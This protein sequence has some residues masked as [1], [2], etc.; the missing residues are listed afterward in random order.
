MRT[1]FIGFLLFAAALLDAT[2][3]LQ[4]R[5][6]KAKVG[7]YIVTEGGQMVTLLAI[8]S[9]HSGTLI[10][11]E[12]SA[13]LSRLQ[14]M[15]TS[16]PEWI[17]AKAPGHT[18]W[19]M[20]EIDLAHGQVLECFSFSRSAWIQT[21]QN[22]SLIATLLQLPLKKVS[23]EARKKIGPAPL[24]DEPDRRK[25]W[26]PP[27]MHEGK[28][29]EGARFDAFEAIWPKDGTELAGQEVL[30]YFDQGKHF[31]LPFWVEINTSHATV[32]LRTIDSGINIPVIHKSMPRRAPEFIG[33]ALK[34]E[35]GLR[36]SIK[37]PKYYRQ[38]E[39]FAIDIT[40]RDK[41]ICPITHFAS[42]ETGEYLTLDID[43]DELQ[44]SLEPKHHYTW[45][46]VPIGHTQSY[47]E[48]QKSFVWTE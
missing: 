30:L 35:K 19:S 37:S 36:L 42:Q 39:L 9:N 5:L 24:S 13:P 22:E 4:E 11:E 45:L 16:W 48:S 38:F 8:R 40:T 12:I 28:Q 26:H 29:R 3:P 14:P 41:Q 7:D 27:L 32:S 17:R 2:S 34:T 10:L 43:R 23:D 21:A 1:W 44:A 33:S 47:A 31:P 25:V 18:S 6:E 46:L 15:P 20:T